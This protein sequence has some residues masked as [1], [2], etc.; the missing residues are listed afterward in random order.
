LLSERP[1]HGYSLEKE[2]RGKRFDLICA[3]LQLFTEE[4]LCHWVSS[5]VRATETTQG[6]ALP[7]GMG[8]TISVMYASS[9]RYGCLIGKNLAGL[10]RLARKIV[11]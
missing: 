5:A 3:G 8:V 1:G 4:M 11:F 7:L 9:G 10:K 2:L 6:E